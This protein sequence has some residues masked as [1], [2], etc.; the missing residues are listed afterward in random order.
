[1]LNLISFSVICPHVKENPTI[2]KSNPSFPTGKERTQ[3][4]SRALIRRHKHT[5]F[6][7]CTTKY[8]RQMYCN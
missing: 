3:R 6:D 4:S 1:M 8:T 7:R 2:Q 5:S